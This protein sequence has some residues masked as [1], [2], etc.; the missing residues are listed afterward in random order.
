[1]RVARRFSVVTNSVFM[2]D[3]LVTLPSSSRE[4]EASDILAVIGGIQVVFVAVE[5]LRSA[6]S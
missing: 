6:F 3:T 4:L 1:M 5:K 2:S